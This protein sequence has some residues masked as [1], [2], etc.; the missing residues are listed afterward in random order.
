MRKKISMLKSLM[1]TFK[2]Q[3]EHSFIVAIHSFRLR[4]RR[5]SHP[6][7]HQALEFEVGLRVLSVKHASGL[8][9]YASMLQTL[10]NAAGLCQ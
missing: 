6:L 9:E 8:H 5:L 10:Q 7:I 4:A 2:L 1:N 3:K